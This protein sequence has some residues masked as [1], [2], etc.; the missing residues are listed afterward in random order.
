[1]SAPELI[2]PE[3]WAC[4][5]FISDLHLEAGDPATVAAWRAYLRSSPADALVI[6]GDLF[7]VWVGDDVLGAAGAADSFE[8]DCCHALLSAAQQRSLFLLHGNRDFLLGPAFAR[9]A[10]LSLLADPTVLVFGGQ[11]WLLS[12]GDALCLDDTEYQQFRQQVRS[13]DWQQAFLAQPLAARQSMARTLR[14][15]SEARKQ[16]GVAYVDLDPAATRA[17]LTLNRAFTL[18]HGHTHR[19]A[20]HD[21]GAGLQRLVL[22]DWDL[23]APRPRAEVLRLSMDHA[24]PGD[25]VRVQ[26]I[27]LAATAPPH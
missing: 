12:H 27:P 13:A 22:S 21:L 19:P 18:I 2:A 25:A 6:L 17:W 15:Q 20:T 7:E 11:R 24:N 5:D 8:A 23:S 9:A 16:S 26:R 10:G 3:R 14:R 1:M 4:I